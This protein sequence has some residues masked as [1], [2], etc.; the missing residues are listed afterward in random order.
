MEK[1]IQ[2]KDNIF[3]LNV[4]KW[5]EKTS[6]IITVY[7]NTDILGKELKNINFESENE[8]NNTYNAILKVIE[9]I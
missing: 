7:F 6:N 3:N 4:I 9:K 1:F 8:C 2:I 5:I